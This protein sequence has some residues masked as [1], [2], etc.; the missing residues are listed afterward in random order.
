MQEAVKQPPQETLDICIPSHESSESGSAAKSSLRGRRTGACGDWHCLASACWQSRRTSST[1]R[2]RL[3]LPPAP[4]LRVSMPRT[5]LAYF[6]NSSFRMSSRF[7]RSM[8]PKHG[9]VVTQRGAMNQNCR[10]PDV[11]DDDHERSGTAT[12]T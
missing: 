8:A 2:H 12:V 3:F 10:G 6:I 9:L 5:F 11:D 4:F 7:R 1:E